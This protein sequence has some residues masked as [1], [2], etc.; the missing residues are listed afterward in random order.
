[1]ILGIDASTP[2]SGGG[3]RHLIELLQS[4]VPGQHGI[5]K[6]KI[7]GVTSLLEQLPDA[8]WLV[9]LS[10]PFLNKGL[11]YR[12]IWQ[13]FLREKTFEN[14][15]HVLFSPFGTYIGTFRPYVTMSRNMLIFD[16]T[17]RNR[18]GFSFMFFKLKFLFYTQKR[19]FTNAQGLIFISKYAN[20]VISN[21]L[22]I[23]H[24]QTRIINHGISKNFIKLP[25]NQKKI[26]EYSNKTPFKFL[27][28][29]SV[30]VYK[31]HCNVV[32]AVASL[33]ARGYPIILDIV[34]NEEQKKIGRKLQY[35]ISFCDPDNMFIK[36]Y[37]NV[38]L[39]S[40]VRFYHSAD[41]F[42]FASTCENMPNILLEAMSAGLPIVC[43]SY[44]PMPEFLK[45]GGIYFD[46]V[47]VSD[48]ENA[49]EKM[50]LNVELRTKITSLSYAEA[51]QYSWE[52]CAEQTFSFL[53]QLANKNKF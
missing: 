18:F 44:E 51:K 31:H 34:G 33:R 24:V 48:I 17:E 43:S 5:E 2:G 22:N 20:K 23:A 47:K 26:T 36:W 50:I 29:S 19:S 49:L 13:I 39:S 28:V 46:P 8:S 30:L 32:R 14:Q 16:R 52:K 15:F 4:F 42:I 35:E 41:A 6:I 11:Y 27:Y 3:K 40:V 10:H 45:E 7:W 1:M 25:V 38:E 53:E 37:K 9:K 21:K 12:I